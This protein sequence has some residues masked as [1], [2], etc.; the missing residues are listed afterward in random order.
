MVR[1]QATAKYVRTSAQKAGL[2]L[3]LIRGKDINRALSALQ[4][5]KKAVAR[6]VAKVLRSAVANAQQQDSF[7]GDVERL[8]V[9]KCHADNGPSMKRVRPAPMGRA[10]RIVKRT[11]HLTVEVTERPQIIRAVG[12]EEGGAAK[13]ARRTAKTATAKTGA[14][15]TAK[16]KKPSPAKA[17]AGKE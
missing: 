16:A 6:D 2:V 12:T 17:A 13:P 11:T 14:K 4:F 9:S 8:F 5:S 10:F 7:G 3:D 1:A 15:K